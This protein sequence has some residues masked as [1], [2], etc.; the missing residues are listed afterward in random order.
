MWNYS[1]PQR[2]PAS[3]GQSSGYFN[4]QES[5]VLI[6]RFSSWDQTA[7]GEIIMN[8]LSFLV[9]DANTGL[10]GMSMGRNLLCIS[11]LIAISSMCTLSLWRA[12]WTWGTCPFP[13]KVQIICH[14][15]HGKRWAWAAGICWGSSPISPLLTCCFINTPGKRKR[16][17]YA[18]QETLLSKVWEPVQMISSADVLNY[19]DSSFFW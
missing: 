2:H 7:W 11:F 1:V 19:R 10:Q 6:T 4:T 17:G 8:V 18:F 12:W 9:S 13:S 5:T 15:P 3:T 16:K 14:M